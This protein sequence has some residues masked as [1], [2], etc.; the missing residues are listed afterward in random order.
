[1]NSYRR[2]LPRFVWQTSNQKLLEQ[3]IL[4]MDMNY[5]KLKKNISNLSKYGSAPE[6]YRIRVNRQKGLLEP[7]RIPL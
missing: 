6:F 7:N 5:L 4:D 1:M 3:S 2:I